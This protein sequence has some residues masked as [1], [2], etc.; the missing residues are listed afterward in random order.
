MENRLTRFYH[1]KSI[2]VCH[3]GNNVGKSPLSAEIVFNK[4]ILQARIKF[5]I[6]PNWVSRN[7]STHWVPGTQPPSGALHE[8]LSHA[9]IKK[10]LFFFLMLHEQSDHIFQ[11][12]TNI[13]HTPKNLLLNLILC[14][15]NFRELFTVSKSSA[16]NV[17]LQLIYWSKNTA[18]GAFSVKGAK[19][20]ERK[21]TR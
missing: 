21:A 2:K 4:S 8:T 17:F 9:D 12:E 1:H 15:N 11:N 14:L 6:P 20:N 16:F 13:M 7:M 3:I 18:F 10:F 5:K 19:K